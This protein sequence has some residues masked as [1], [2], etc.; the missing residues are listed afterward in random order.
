MMSSWPMLSRD[1]VFLATTSYSVGRASTKIVYSMWSPSTKPVVCISVARS[2]I[3][4]NSSSRLLPGAISTLFMRRERSDLVPAV[5][6]AVQRK[7]AS[8]APL[9]DVHQCNILLSLLIL[10]TGDKNA[11]FQRMPLDTLGPEPPRDK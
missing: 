7:S 2:T 11:I 8:Y 9:G 6:K 3:L 1:S 4:P 5:L 10:R